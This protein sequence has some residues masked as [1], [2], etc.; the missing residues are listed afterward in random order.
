[1]RAAIDSLSLKDETAK[2]EKRI[3]TLYKNAT[4][5]ALSV[6]N[7]W[8]IYTEENSRTAHQSVNFHFNILVFLLS[9][10]QE[11]RRG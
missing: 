6:K 7:K 4:V 3:S 8:N 1:M 2:N 11:S 5:S 9:V 10:S